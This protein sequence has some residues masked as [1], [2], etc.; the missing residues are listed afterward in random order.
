MRTWTRMPLA[1]LAAVAPAA[2]V[3]AAALALAT[4][5][6]PGRARAATPPDT[7]VI[8]YNR[9]ANNLLPGQNPS[10]PNI[11]ANMLIYDCLV[12][13]DAQGR[14]HPA[15]AKRWESSSDGTVWTFY[16]R[17]DVTFHSGRKFTARDVKAHFDLWK[18]LPTA[19]KIAAL[20]KTEVV[21][22]YTVRFTL[23]YP[24]LVFLNMISQTEWSYCG[25]PDSEAVAKYGKDYGVRPESVS[26]TG[27]FR[28][29]RWVREDRMEFERNPA[30]R[31]GPAFYANRGPARIE[32]VVIRSIPDSAARTAAL[33]RNEI[34]MDISLAE[35]DA[36]R[37]SQ[38][39][40]LRVIV[41]PKHTIHHL[42][43]NFQKPLWS[44]VR[45]RRALAHAVDQ[46]PIV[47]AVYSGYAT[48]A[49][50]LFADSVEGSVPDAEMAKIHLGYDPARA[51]RLL[52]EAG[53]KPGPDGI[54]VKDGQ[55]LAFTVYIYTET[56]ANLMTIVQEQWREIGAE[57]TIRQLEYAAHQEATKRGEHDMRYVDGTHSTADIAYWFTC[58]ARPHPNNLFWCDPTTD[59]LFEQTQRTTDS[60]VRVKAFRELETRLVEQAVVIPMPH[61]SWVVGVWDSVKD[62]ELHPIHGYYKLLDARKSAR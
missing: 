36:R 28:L 26:G 42:G 16:L 18:T 53:W 48:P 37:L 54:R 32:K 43:F 52:D 46:R 30:Y 44:D 29:V 31:W 58:A 13:H 61:T 9:A 2:L 17:D 25:I 50:G 38:V 12:I 14:I 51:R 57:A 45:V 10:L 15:L 19:S 55:R 1:A 27:P 62:L 49:I 20:D 11:W 60:A 23:K 33:E 4:A 59:R 22:D 56:Q 7:L 39:K 35:T 24:T 34:D 6:V 40:G 5:L 47:E 3:L 8:G 21:D 41:Q